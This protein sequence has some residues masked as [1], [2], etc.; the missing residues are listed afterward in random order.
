[1]NYY[2][3]TLSSYLQFNYLSHFLLTL[4]LIPLMKK[5]PDARIINV[6][7]AA[8]NNGEFNIKN[9]QGFSNYDKAKF[10]ANS[11]LYQVYKIM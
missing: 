7:S 4:H 1:M 10:F 3:V 2:N 9:V 5:L 8:H 6:T 11:Q